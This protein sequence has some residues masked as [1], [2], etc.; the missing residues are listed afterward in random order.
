MFGWGLYRKDY[1][2]GLEIA[3][4]HWFEKS[5]QQ[6]FELKLANDEN[7]RLFDYHN[8]KLTKPKR[9]KNGVLR[10]PDGTFAK[11]K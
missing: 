4:N 6:L 8:N 9:D 3:K 5:R 1:V 2:E 10:N 7:K 11:V